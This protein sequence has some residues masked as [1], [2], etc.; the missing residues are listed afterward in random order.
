MLFANAGDVTAKRH[1]VLR[2]AEFEPVKIAGQIGRGIAGEQ[3]DLVPQRTQRKTCRRAVV[4]ILFVHH[5]KT[6]RGYGRIV[7]E[8]VFF[9]FIEIVGQKPAADVHRVGGG[10]VEL[11]RIDLRQIGVGERFIDPDRRERRGRGIGE[12]GRAV[13]VAA[14]PP[15]ELVTPGVQ[16]RVFVHD[17]ER[18]TEAIGD[19][20][21]GVV[22]PE[23]ENGF[24][25]AA[26]EGEPLAGVVQTAR[27]LAGDVADGRVTRRKCRPVLHEQGGLPR[28]EGG[29]AAGGGE[30]VIDAVGEAHADQIQRAGAD[31]LQLEVFK[32]IREIGAARRGD[33]VIHDFG[34]HHGRRGDHK[35]RCSR[36]GP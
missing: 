34:D 15:T 4:E 35:R 32:I 33:G 30:G 22:V 12:A 10:V 27:I 31:V 19:R 23:I 8:A 6:A 26:D 18:K 21:P 2:R 11:H 3:P 36:P 14:G 13:H 24:E 25:R 7:G 1:A 20:I 9:R 17:D 16:R 28:A 5:Q 29:D